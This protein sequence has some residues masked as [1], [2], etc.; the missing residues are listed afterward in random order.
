M[1]TKQDNQPHYCRAKVSNGWMVTVCD[2]QCDYCKIQQEQTPPLR[3]TNTY[4]ESGVSY[5]P[6][7]GFI[8]ALIVVL[9]ILF[10]IFYS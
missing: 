1:T 10:Q 2:E 6:S 8:I 9:W 5:P 4:I 3:D 7:W